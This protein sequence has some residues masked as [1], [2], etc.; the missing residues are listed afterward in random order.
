[1]QRF[2]ASFGCFELHINQI[3]K[4]WQ[5]RSCGLWHTADACAAF[6]CC[7]GWRRFNETFIVDYVA[8][9][10]GIKVDEVGMDHGLHC[11]A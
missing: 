11:Q 2:L 4:I 1:M 9:M 10:R 7:S 5:H 3:G 6:H 8:T